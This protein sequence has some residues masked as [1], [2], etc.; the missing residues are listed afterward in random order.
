MNLA[1]FI[2][3]MKSHAA[4]LANVNELRHIGVK[5]KT[6]VSNT[7]EMVDVIPFR[8]EFF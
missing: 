3:A 2:Q 1:N 4:D 8:P 6:Q 5:L 7:V